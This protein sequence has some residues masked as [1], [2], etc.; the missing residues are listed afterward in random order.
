MTL[1]PTAVD[2]GNSSSHEKVVLQKRSLL[3]NVALAPVGLV[4]H[5]L[6][7]E[8]MSAKISAPEMKLKPRKSPKIPPTLPTKDIVVIFSW[9]KNL[10]T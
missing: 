8:T 7:I 4:K 3:S 9:V 2:M 5:L 10:V 1:S 6:G